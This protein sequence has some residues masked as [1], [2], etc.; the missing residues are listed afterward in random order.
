MAV[1]AVHKTLVLLQ[2][3]RGHQVF[4][5]RVYIFG[6]VA[7]PVVHSYPGDVLA[8]FVQ[9]QIPYVAGYVPVN[10]PCLTWR[11]TAYLEHHYVVL[12]GVLLIGQEVL[13]DL[14]PVFGELLRP[15]TLL[16]GIAGGPQVRDRRGNRPRMRIKRH[17]VHLP[18]PRYLRLDEPW[19]SGS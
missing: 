11:A 8:L 6:K 19:R 17:R 1:H 10:V 5:G 14:Q 12:D 7:C 16:A 13:I 15:V 4:L 3:L 9:G 18:Q 2:A